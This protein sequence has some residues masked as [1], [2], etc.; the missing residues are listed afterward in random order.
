MIASF[1]TQTVTVERPRMTPS[2]GSEVAD[3]SRPEVF[4]VP[5]CS[6]QPGAFETERDGRA[7]NVQ[8][9][10][11]MWAPPDAD[12]RLGD[13]VHALGE[14]WSVEAAPPAWP[15]GAGQLAHREIALRLWKG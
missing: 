7:A 11:R 10:A 5:G 4:E 1:C 6:V 14:T 15:A 3:W 12:V 2:R 13:R 8:G 9:G